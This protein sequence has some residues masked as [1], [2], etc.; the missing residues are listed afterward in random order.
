MRMQERIK[1]MSAE[2]L[3]SMVKPYLWK[4]FVSS[5]YANV[6]VLNKILV[7]SANAFSESKPDR[8][9]E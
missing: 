8:R 7:Q 3:E 2:E 9:T 5:I 6:A 4:R 1:M